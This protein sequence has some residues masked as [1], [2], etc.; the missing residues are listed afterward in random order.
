MIELVKVRDA[1]DIDAVRVLAWEFVDF[2]H[3]RYPEMRAE[4]ERYLASQ[5][6]EGML[7]D[8]TSHFNP[9]TG[10]CL[11]AKKDGEAAGIVML[12]RLEG[13]ACEMNRMFV[14]PALR[15]GG[16]GRALCRALFDEAR[17][18]GYRE[19]RLSALYRHDEALSLYGSLGFERSVPFGGAGDHDDERVV[20]MRLSLSEAPA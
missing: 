1:G 20:F 10:E 15:G 18:L 16:V 5:N 17:A 2:L 12:K 6:F 3:D 8:F 19:V 9:P 14:R 4:T 7:A 13:P 11:L